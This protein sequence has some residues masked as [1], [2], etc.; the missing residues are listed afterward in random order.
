MISV[1]L[2][3]LCVACVALTSLLVN[4]AKPICELLGL[5]DT[6]D[7]RKLHQRETPLMGG[8]TLIFVILPLFIVANF[9]V[10]DPS[11]RWLV[12]LITIATAII[13]IIGMADDRHSLSATNRIILTS[14]TFAFVASVEPMFNVRYL[15]FAITN[16]PIDVGMAV[17]PIAV[18]FTTL[19]CVGLVNAINMADGK[20]GLVTG[21]CLGWL[22]L[23]YSRAPA[24]LM[25]FILIILAAMTI[26]FIS[27]LRGWLFL[28]DGGSYGFGAVIAFITIITYNSY[29]ASGVRA[30]YAEEA[31]LLFAVPVFDSFRL[32]FVRM[33]RGQSPMAGD[34]DHLHHHLLNRFGWPLG[35]MVYLTIAL[36]PSLS[37]FFLRA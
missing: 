32:T 4:F 33:R 37:L 8:P 21:L 5:M 18:F 34:R 3:L 7:T 24:P 22:M 13:A 31:M 26:L 11:Y 9:T 6:P 30:M 12:T 16:P 20:N 14:L 29:D 17:T 10:V 23:L 28:G 25:P 36:M 27:N 35:L 19:C 1:T 2:I 15:Q